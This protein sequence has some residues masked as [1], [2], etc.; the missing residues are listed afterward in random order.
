MEPSAAGLAIAHRE[1]G[2]DVEAG[3]APRPPLTLGFAVL[4]AAAPLLAAALL[5]PAAPGRALSVWGVGTVV[6]MC[7]RFV[8]FGRE[9]A[10]LRLEL[11]EQRIRAV[12]HYHLHEFRSW[13]HGW[14]E[15]AGCTWSRAELV[16][17]LRS[18][19]SVRWHLPSR[20]PEQLA[21]LA[22]TIQA[23]V[24]RRKAFERDLEARAGDRAAVEALR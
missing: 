18:G 24:A 17:H 14:G 11:T 20:S 23:A 9:E 2:L 12:R 10:M 7:W 8:Q 15:V 3:A 22:T 16:L 19:R 1:H 21:W 5:D 6:A 13:S 4:F